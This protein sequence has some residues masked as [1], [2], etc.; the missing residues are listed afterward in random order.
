M[1]LSTRDLKGSKWLVWNSIWK[2]S[3]TSVTHCTIEYIRH[4]VAL[5]IRHSVRNTTYRDEIFDENTE[6]LEVSIENILN[7]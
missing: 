7:V 4:D 6:Y 5:H 2:Q 1:K 3:Y